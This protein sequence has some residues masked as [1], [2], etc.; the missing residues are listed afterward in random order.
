MLH[1]EKNFAHASLR[2][3]ALLHFILIKDLNLGSR[4]GP[5]L[6]LDNLICIIF[7]LFYIYPSSTMLAH[8][9]KNLSVFLLSISYSLNLNYGDIH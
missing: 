1:L 9:I 7:T 4:E 6:G 5:T 2:A 8:S 3:P